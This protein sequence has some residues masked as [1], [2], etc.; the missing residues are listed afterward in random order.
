MRIRFVLTFG[1]VMLLL[2]CSKD[3][4]VYDP[5]HSD[6]PFYGTSMNL[7]PIDVPC[8]YTLN[9]LG[10]DYSGTP[11]TLNPTYEYDPYY[12]VE[13]DWGVEAIEVNGAGFVD[14]RLKID[15]LEKPTTGK[16]VTVAPTNSLLGPNECIV[17]GSF[18]T[19]GSFQ[20]ITATA[21]DT[22]YVSALNQGKMQFSFCNVHMYVEDPQSGGGVIVYEFDTS[23]GNI[24]IE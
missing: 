21:G 1:V 24:N 15:F 14:Q 19:G 16:Y 8:S 10:S 4:F 12:N 17:S 20:S 3:D 5:E 18:I 7:K 6:D 13:A 2:A 23:S 9:S 11:M 22:V